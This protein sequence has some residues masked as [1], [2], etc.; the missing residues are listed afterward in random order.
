MQCIVLQ[1][2]IQSITKELLVKV[3]EFNTG[4]GEILKSI[5]CITINLIFFYFEMMLGIFMPGHQI[6]NANLRMFEVE[7]VTKIWVLYLNKPD[8]KICLRFRVTS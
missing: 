8:Q 4:T 3:L 6:L 7:N 5:T 2:I 1:Q